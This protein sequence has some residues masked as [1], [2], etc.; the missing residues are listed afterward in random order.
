[1]KL[2]ALFFMTTIC[3]IGCNQSDKQTS[4]NNYT[5][6]TKTVKI[7]ED[8]CFEY[9]KNG[10]TADVKLNFKGDSLSG[11]MQN[12]NAEKDSNYGKLSGILKDD[13]IKA[14]YQF[15]SEGQISTMQVQFKMEDGKLIQGFGEMEEKGGKMVFKENAEIDYT[16]AFE[17]KDC[18]N[19]SF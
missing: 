8:Q 7:I 17:K 10:F 3:F 19:I 16:L 14:E 1:M 9:S 6:K 13:I 15:Q 11:Q 2:K 4:N 5:A 12:L 18:K